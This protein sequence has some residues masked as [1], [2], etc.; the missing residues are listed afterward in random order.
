MQGAE[1]KLS[2]TLTRNL[3]S[4][5]ALLPLLVLL[6]LAAVYHNLNSIPPVYFSRLEHSQWTISDAGKNYVPAHLPAGEKSSGAEMPEG[7]ATFTASLAYQGEA[8]VGFDIST[9]VPLTIS[10]YYIKTDG[11]KIP[12]P[13]LAASPS[14][15]YWSTITV[16]IPQNLRSSLTG[17]I[18]KMHSRIPNGWIAARNLALFSTHNTSH[19][20]NWELAQ[21]N[22][23]LIAVSLLLGVAVTGACLCC[24]YPSVLFISSAI[25]ALALTSIYPELFYYWDEWSMLNRFSKIGIKAIWTPHNEHS[26]PLF[27]ALYW[28]ETTLAGSH[29]FW[30]LIISIACQ[31]LNAVLTLKFIRLHTSLSQIS[32]RLLLTAFI[33]SALATEVLQWA[34]V[35]C[36]SLCLTCVLLALIGGTNYYRTGRIRQLFHTGLAAVAAPLF[37]GN[38]FIVLPLLIAVLCLSLFFQK[39]ES[40]EAFQGG[41]IVKLLSATTIATALSVAFYLLTKPANASFSHTAGSSN[42]LDHI[43]EILNYIFVGSQAGTIARG[44]GILPGLGNGAPGAIT[45]TLSLPVEPLFFFAMLGLA[46]NL[47]LLLFY[48]LKLEQSA[49]FFWLLGQIF[50]LSSFAL[51]ALGRYDL[52][53]LQAMSLRYHAFALPGLIFLLTPLAQFFSGKNWSVAGR[54]VVFVLLSIFFSLQFFMKGR[55]SDFQEYGAANRSFIARLEQW[56]SDIPEAESYK[57]GYYE[58]PHS[59]KANLYPALPGTLTPGMHPLQ[60]LKTYR[61]L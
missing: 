44:L 27:F 21:T 14:A 15:D 13:E 57:P 56:V 1:G 34:F 18:L 6:L 35:Q 23:M 36:I 28:L 12:G 38:G 49:L 52:G 7:R 37:F 10:T 8:A 58:A 60:V 54:S 19:Q 31:V 43:G 2:R 33:F 47:G 4:V 9:S 11:S 46:V 30:L 41:R 5:M 25:T 45:A 3:H 61:E 50:I 17:I 26:L 22:L 20:P 32:E 42:P 24:S 59:D 51:P 55:M 29:Y 40:S 16:S 39:S 53:T 48:L